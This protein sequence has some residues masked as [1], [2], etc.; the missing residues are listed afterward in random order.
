MKVKNKRLIT[1]E[2]SSKRN[3][4]RATLSTSWFLPRKIENQ[5]GRGSY[6]RKDRNGGSAKLS[7]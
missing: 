4:I 5:K 1:V 6:S 3:G 2:V 7:D